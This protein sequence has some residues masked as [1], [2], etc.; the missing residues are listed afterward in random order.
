M[1]KINLQKQFSVPK[2]PNPVCPFSACHSDKI[3][4]LVPFFDFSNC[5]RGIV[6]L[7]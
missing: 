7:A 3:A 5:S 2:Y 6:V 1:E 4:I